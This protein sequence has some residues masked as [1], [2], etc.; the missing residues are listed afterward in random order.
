M[1]VPHAI[2]CARERAHLYG[3]DAVILEKQA[4]ALAPGPLPAT[5]HDCTENQLR[6]LLL[7]MQAQ[8]CRRRYFRELEAIDLLLGRGPSSFAE[9]G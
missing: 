5:V 4:D 2:R 6:A 7:A 9:L 8:Q 1:T 3:A